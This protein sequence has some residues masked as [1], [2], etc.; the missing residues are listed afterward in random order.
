MADEATTEEVTRDGEPTPSP[1]PQQTPDEEE[2]K[3]SKTAVL[4]DLATERDKRQALETQF[5]TLRDGLAAALGL[6]QEEPATP[7][8]L[9]EQLTTAQREAAQ[10]KVELA[11][12]RSTPDGVDAQALIDSRAFTTSISDIDPGDTDALTA[13]INSF[14]ET[15]PRFRNGP[16]NPGG[17]DAATGGRP[18]VGAETMDDLL[19]G[20]R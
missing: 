2:G 15:H 5:N 7:E 14:V 1:E 6:N 9:T 19:R 13:A 8:Q 10:A 16:V 20:R 18:P 11:V 17:R 12:F 3:G 4:A